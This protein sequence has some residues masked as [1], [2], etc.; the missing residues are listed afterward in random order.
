M[1]KVLEA[2]EF[3]AERGGG[4]DYGTLAGVW[5]LGLYSARSSSG[6]FLRFTQDD[7]RE[8]LKHYREATR[9]D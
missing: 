5:Y 1:D 3:M 9:D 7:V 6:D 8:F 2:L 4:W